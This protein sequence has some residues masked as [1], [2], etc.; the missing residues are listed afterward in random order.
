MTP[1][2]SIQT[3]TRLQTVKKAH[4]LSVKYHRTTLGACSLSLFSCQHC[5][6]HRCCLVW[7]VWRKLWCHHFPN[8]L[9]HI[10]TRIRRNLN[11]ENRLSGSCLLN[12]FVHMLKRNPP[13]PP[14]KKEEKVCFAKSPCSPSIYP[15]A[16]WWFIIKW[17]GSYHCY[18]C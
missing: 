1:N 13:P 11:L 5:G 6:R 12:S 16:I 14:P 15:A 10:D 7:H 9:L 4:Q 2:V 8:T 3:R 18:I 17:R